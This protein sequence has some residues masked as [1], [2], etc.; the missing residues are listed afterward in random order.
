MIVF[1]LVLLVLLY[2]V[3]IA[4]AYQ[5]GMEAGRKEEK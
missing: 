4:F 2:C 3:S 5:L 1:A